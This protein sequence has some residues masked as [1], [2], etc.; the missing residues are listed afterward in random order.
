MK[1]IKVVSSNVVAVGYEENKLYVDKNKRNISIWDN[2]NYITVGE[3]GKTMS[4]EDIDA[5]I[6][7]VERLKGSNK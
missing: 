3:G 7:I 4:N 1:M 6:S 5:L 2:G